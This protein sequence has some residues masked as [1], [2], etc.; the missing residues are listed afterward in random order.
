MEEWAVARIASQ[1][2]ARHADKLTTEVREKWLGNWVIRSEDMGKTWQAPVRTV[3]TAP[4]DPIQ[5]ADGRL[6]YVGIGRSQGERQV[7]VEDSKD[8]GRSWSVI[9]TIPKP[10]NTREFALV[11]FSR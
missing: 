5:L 4:H 9:A 8:D 1:R 2:Y 3:S 10:M 6:L 11:Y 7:T